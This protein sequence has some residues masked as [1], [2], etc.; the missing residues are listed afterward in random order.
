MI[1]FLTETKEILAKINKIP[2]DITYIG[3][4][5]ENPDKNYS[6]TWKEFETLAAF[7][8]DNGYGGHEIPGDLIVIF[9][10]KSWLSRGEYD[11]SE[12]WEYNKCP[13][14]PI[15][16]NKITTFKLKQAWP[17]FDSDSLFD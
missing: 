16:T 5:S 13:K 11:G 7:R 12:W 17:Y 15:K 9:S 8:Y 2:A 10:D 3:N 14:I 6:C 1:N 4:I